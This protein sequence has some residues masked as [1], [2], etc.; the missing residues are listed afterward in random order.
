MKYLIAVVVL[1]LATLVSVPKLYETVDAGEIVVIQDP[2]DGEV[3]VYQQ[4]GLQWQGFGSVTT[5]K[6]SNQFWFTAGEGEGA[7]DNSIPVKWNDGGH[8]RI[9]GSVRYDLPL[10]EKRMIALH[11]TFGSQEAIE[12]SLIKTNIEKAVYMTG[13]LMSSKES[14]AEKRND[15]I[16][17]IEDQASKGV[18]RTEQIDVKAIDPLSGEEKT[19]TKVR[20]VLDSTNKLPVRQE[21]SPI[22]KSGIQ[23][24]NISVNGMKYSADV[25]KQIQ[26]QQQATMQVQTAIANAKRAEQEAITVAK[27]GEADAAKA[28]WE[29][30]VIKAKLVTEAEA[31]NKVAQLAVQTAELEKRRKILQGEGEAAQKRLVMQADGAL[32]QK[33]R[34]YIQVQQAWADAFSKYQGAI[35]PTIS[36]S[37]TNSNGATNFMELMGAKAARDLALDLRQAK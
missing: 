19:V 21:A 34:A 9:S 27:Q 28:K 14:Y 8:A 35:V 29:Q 22:Y 26:T 15:I 30:E 25:E 7:A 2:V 24:Y 11:S 32:E 5:Y 37:G 16:A 4:P 13:P 36:S 10:D 31:A 20:I 6:K 33:L 3:H 18:Y 12:N 17:Y 1:V 23:L